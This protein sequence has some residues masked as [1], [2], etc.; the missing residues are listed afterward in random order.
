MQI[1][2][3]ALLLGR[4]AVEGSFQMEPLTLMSLPHRRAHLRLCLER[5]KVLIP[6]GPDCTRHTTLGLLN[7][8]KAHIKSGP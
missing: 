7:K 1:S 6:L 8:A 2:A 5:L 4:V 3:G